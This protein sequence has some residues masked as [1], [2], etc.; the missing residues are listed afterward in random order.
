MLEGADVELDVEKA[1][2]GRTWE[3][4]VAGWYYVKP[5]YPGRASHVRCL[6]LSPAS[7]IPF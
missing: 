3:E 7:N 1:R 6:Y 2:K 4:C 5:N